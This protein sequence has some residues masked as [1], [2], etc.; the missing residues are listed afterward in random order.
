MSR[1]GRPNQLG[2]K[3]SFVIVSL[4]SLPFN[5]IYR[6]V[7]YS[8]STGHKT[9]ETQSEEPFGPVRGQESWEHTSCHT[10]F[11]ETRV[12]DD[13]DDDDD[14]ANAYKRKRVSAV[15]A[16]ARSAWI[17]LGNEVG[18]WTSSTVNASTMPQERRNALILIVAPKES[19]VTVAGV[20]WGRSCMRPFWCS[21]AKSLNVVSRE[22]ILLFLC[23]FHVVFAPSFSGLFSCYVF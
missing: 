14:D 19:P 6:P 17:L 8:A 7:E 1:R 9:V 3:S 18:R 5:V 4:V 23:L 15:L 2:E 12:P 21:P 13:D 20:R 22:K 11:C 10:V 16:H